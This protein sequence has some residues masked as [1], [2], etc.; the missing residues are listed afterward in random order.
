MF[1]LFPTLQLCNSSTSRT[2]RV[3][4]I[5]RLLNEHASTIAAIAVEPL[6]QAAAGII[7]FIRPGFLRGLRALADRY[8]VLLICDEIAVGFGRTGTMFACEHEGVRPDLMCVGKGLTGGYLPLAATLA[9]RAIYDAFLG[10]PWSG[11]TFFHGHTFTGNPLACAAAIASIELFKTNDTLGNVAARGAE[12]AAMLQA[13]ASHRF[14]GDVRQR[15]LMAGIELVADTTGEDAVRPARPRRGRAVSAGAASRRDPAA[16][17]RRD[18]DRPAAGDRRGTLAADR[19]RDRDRARL[20]R[21][22]A[23][24]RHRD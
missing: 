22:A 11:R 17:G 3:D 2:T 24:V 6:I 8:G 14:V 18:H 7:T 15:G 16:A 13:L 20:D 4:H 19:R 1:R 10:E 12:L 9:T 23:G 21:R 5:E